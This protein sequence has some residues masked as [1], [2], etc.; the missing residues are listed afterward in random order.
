MRH[1]HLDVVCVIQHGG[2]RVGRYDATD[3][4]LLFGVPKVGRNEAA[5]RARLVRYLMD[6]VHD[7]EEVAGVA[8]LVHRRLDPDK[9]ERLQVYVCRH[10]EPERTCRCRI[11]FR[12]DHAADRT[13]SR[14]HHNTSELA[15]WIVITIIDMP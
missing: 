6:L 8:F 13:V 9:V 15:V 14:C 3:S 4:R 11:P 1:R 12:R 2:V 5:Q 10:P 7:C